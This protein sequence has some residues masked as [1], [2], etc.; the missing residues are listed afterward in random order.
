MTKEEFFAALAADKRDIMP[1]IVNEW[2]DGEG[3][4]SEWRDQGLARGH[5][6]TS[7]GPR[8]DGSTAYYL[9]DTI[10]PAEC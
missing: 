4:R 2:V 5:F 7:C 8:R 9:S 1:R 3:Y 10:R 6:G